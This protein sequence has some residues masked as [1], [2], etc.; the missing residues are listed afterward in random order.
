VVGRSPLFESANLFVRRELF[1]RLGGFESWLGPRNGKEL[2]EDVWFGWRAVRAGA[3]IAACREAL[4]HHEVYPRGPLGFATERWRLRFFPEM[5]GRIPELRRAFLHRRLFLSARAARFDAALVG[6]A[7]AVLAR[8]PLAAAAA[9][10]YLR[11]L[12]HDVREPD[13]ARKAA[14]RL[15]A[16]AVGATALIVGSARSRSPML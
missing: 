14:A 6:V 11:V 1:E 9:L 15:A 13:G 12:S 2:G 4:V 5:V 8:R 7:L 10:P 3:R 16:D